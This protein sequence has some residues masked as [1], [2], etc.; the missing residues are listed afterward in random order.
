MLPGESP[1]DIRE[2][3][4]KY[5]SAAFIDALG[6]RL[7]IEIAK[8]SEYP[9]LPPMHSYEM[10]R[11]NDLFNSTILFDRGGKYTSTKEL[12]QRRYDRD[13]SFIYYY[14]NAANIV[15]PVKD[16]IYRQMEVLQLEQD[17]KAVKKF[18]KSN[19]FNGIKN[20]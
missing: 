19:L 16:E 20:M 10:R 5:Q 7:V 4:E 11:A 18:T 2:Y 6:V 3:N 15:P 14:D 9:T 17:T 12:A 1:E 8:S 13:S